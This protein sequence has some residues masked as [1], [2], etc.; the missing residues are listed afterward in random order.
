MFFIIGLTFARPEHNF[1]SFLGFGHGR[2]PSSPISLCSNT[3]I[4]Q[5]YLNQTLALVNNLQ[6]NPSWN[7]TL[8]LT[9]ANFV[10]CLKNSTNQAMITTNCPLF[11][12]TLR[13]AKILDVAAKNTRQQLACSL[14]QQFQ[15]VIR[16]VTGGYG[17]NELDVNDH[18]HSGERRC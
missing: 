2:P 7:S 4:A 17:R 11:V 16:N 13:A 12:A 1:F 3:T 15:Q 8:Q 6:A 14:E 18:G 10:A 5:L 9:S